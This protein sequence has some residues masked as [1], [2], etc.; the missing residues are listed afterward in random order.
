MADI[1]IHIASPILGANQGFHVRQWDGTTWTDLG[2]FT[3]ND[4]D[5]TGLTEGECYDFAITFLQSLSPLVECNQ[6][7]RTY[8]VPA[9]Q[10]CV[11]VTGE[12]EAVGDNYNL[13]LT[14]GLPSPY[15]VPCGGYI[16]EYG[17]NAPYTTVPFPD[18]AGL[19][20]LS[21]P[22]SVNGTYHV[23]IYAIDCSGNRL[24]CDEISVTPLIPPPCTHADVVSAVIN[25]NSGIYSITLTFTPSS[26]NSSIY[27]LSWFQAGVMATGTPDVGGAVNVTGTGANPQVYTFPIAPNLNPVV[28]NG[29]VVLQ[30]AG[31]FTDR[32][33]Y[34]T[35]WY[36][37]YLIRNV[38]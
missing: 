15:S 6:I 21:L 9:A 25:N 19:S 28:I 37:T 31:G 26:P 4:I 24:L 22:V 34:L 12:I 11:T 32:C 7:I 33:N 13:V 16:L 35:K 29:Q 27:G 17:L 18:F 8:C 20:P 38:T 1:T 10:P 36:A 2:Y 14:I 23:A 30:Y 3:T 5:V